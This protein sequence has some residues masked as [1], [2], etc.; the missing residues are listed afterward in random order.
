MTVQCVKFCCFSTVA[1]EWAGRQGLDVLLMP[2]F[3]AFDQ[4]VDV[5]WEDA[6]DLLK[7]EDAPLDRAACLMSGSAAS[8]LAVSSAHV[9]QDDTSA[10]EVRR[11]IQRDWEHHGRH[12]DMTV[13][14]FPTY[15]LAAPFR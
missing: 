6:D 10:V 5:T 3:I 9:I 14:G 1:I 4:G 13:V 2:L 8:C 7:T 11:T 12:A 15:C